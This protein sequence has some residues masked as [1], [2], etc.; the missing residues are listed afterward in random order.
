MWWRSKKFVVI[1][2]VIAVLLVGSVA[3]IAVAQTS[4]PDTQ[5]KSFVAR[6]AAILGI[7]QQKVQSAFDQAQKDM[8]SDRIDAYLKKLVEAGK[9][10]QQQADQYKQWLQS[11]PDMSQY[12]QALKQWQQAKPDVPIPNPGRLFGGMGKFGGFP[13]GR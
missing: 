11:R 8:Q 13:R 5:G 7:D 3:G 12:D 1:A 2:V 9:I 6:V 4:S 10:T